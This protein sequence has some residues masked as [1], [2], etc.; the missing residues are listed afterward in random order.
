[1]KEG[2]TNAVSFPSSLAAATRIRSIPFAL[3][4]NIMH[5]RPVTISSDGWHGGERVEHDEGWWW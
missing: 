2:A 5:R 3:D 1:M 4:D